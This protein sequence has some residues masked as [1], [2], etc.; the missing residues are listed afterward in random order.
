MACAS[1]SSERTD[2]RPAI[3]F[4]SGCGEYQ[5]WRLFSYP[6]NGRDWPLR[7]CSFAVKLN[8]PQYMAKNS[9]GI[10]GRWR[11]IVIDCGACTAALGKPAWVKRKIIL[12]PFIC[13]KN[14]HNTTFYYLI[15]LI[16]RAGCRLPDYWAVAQLTIRR[17][18]RMV[19]IG[20]GPFNLFLLIGEQASPSLHCD[21]YCC[22]STSNIRSHTMALP[23]IL[24]CKEVV[25]QLAGCPVYP[26]R[27]KT[28]R[29]SDSVIL[30]LLCGGETVGL[31]LILLAVNV[32]LSNR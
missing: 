21:F 6:V 4:R 24:F 12:T 19:Q 9:N 5:W 32:M 8:E 11:R 13:Y 7:F 20:V 27:R 3:F 30:F 2:A 15:T 17:Y 23:C 10:S 14:N 25:L 1:R 31:L 26:Q 28:L 29:D 16:S 22:N 18:D